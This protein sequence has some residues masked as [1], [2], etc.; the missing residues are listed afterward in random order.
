MGRTKD[1]PFQQDER[2]CGGGMQIGFE[3]DGLGSPPMSKLLVVDDEPKAL[4]LLEDHLSASGY[5]VETASSYEEAVPILEQRA[6]DLVITDIRLPKR[7][8][9]ELV[10]LISK[11]QPGLPCVVITA[12]GK[13]ADAVRL[14]R[15]GVVDYLEKP[16]DLDALTAVVAKTLE[17]ASLKAEHNYLISHMR[18]DEE[19][20]LLVGSSPV[21]QEARALITRIGKSRSTVLVTGE[22]G[23]GK[24]LVALAIHE[25]GSTRK[26][27]LVRVSCPNI[28]AELF[29]SE[30][31][32]HMKGAFT[33]AVETRKGKF[34]LAN[35]GTI[36]LDEIAEVP[37]ELQPKLLR[38][39]EERVFCRVGGTDDIRVDLRVIAA[40]NRDL[41]EMVRQDRFREDLYYRLSVFPIHL[42]PLR[43]RLED[44][45]EL[46]PHLL[47]HLS[48]AFSVACP[49]ISQD[50]LGKL[51]AY[52][53]PGNVRELRN[54]LER[55]LLLSAGRGID[56]QHLVLHRVCKLAEAPSDPAAGSLADR[57]NLYK[58]RVLVETL[59]ATGWS[60]KEAAERLGLTQRAMSHYV[61][62][63]DLDRYRDSGCIC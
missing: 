26:K 23:T 44:I 13:V 34:E 48:R 41:E 20:P 50:A 57:L 63:Y 8:G 53:W 46:A 24:E 38:V 16:F 12:Y 47:V 60:K 31:F 18:E 61:A 11:T 37:L 51:K 49:S 56:E 59:R 55:A 3:T 52:P 29:E 33:G 54:V 15:L 30:L 4:S 10:E 36:L 2:I 21:M 62:K 39:L 6:I 17:V 35:G 7:S 22:S 43:E 14:L 9:T 42:P 1:I 5:R 32:G 25:A 40:T 27:P 28:S 58:L 45:D 19:T